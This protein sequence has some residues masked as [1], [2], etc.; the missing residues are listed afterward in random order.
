MTNRYMI[1]MPALLPGVRCYAD[2]STTPDHPSMQPRMAGL[3]VFFLNT[4]VQP[5]HAIYIKAVMIN[6]ASVLMAEAAALAL[7]A[8]VNDVMAEAAALALAATVN[9][10]LNINDATFLSD[11]Q[12]LVHFLND[13]DQTNPP[14]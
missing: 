12:Q 1:Q 9:D 8:T 3:G 10:A 11:C 14:D 7:A 13:A 4:Q 2:A 5:V 6:A